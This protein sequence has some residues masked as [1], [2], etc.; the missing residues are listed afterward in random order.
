[1][2]SFFGFVSTYFQFFRRSTN[3]FLVILFHFFYERVV[4]LFEFSG[5]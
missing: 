5:R 2:G 1:M 4:F 3:P